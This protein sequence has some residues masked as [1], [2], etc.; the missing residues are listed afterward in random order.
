MQTVISYLLYTKNIY[1]EEFNLKS[2]VE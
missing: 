2:L 1:E